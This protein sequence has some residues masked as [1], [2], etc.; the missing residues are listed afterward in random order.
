MIGSIVTYPKKQ[1][2][3]EECRVCPRRTLPLHRQRSVRVWNF[4]DLYRHRLMSHIAHELI[5][6]RR[7][8]YCKVRIACRVS[9]GWTSQA[10]PDERR[11]RL[12]VTSHQNEAVDQPRVTLRE[13]R[14][15]GSS[16]TG[17][18]LRAAPAEWF[19]RVL[20]GNTRGP[21]MSSRLR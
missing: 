21:R 3:W 13:G 15:C 1:N 16:S 18:L 2:V 11:D 19:L 17:R 20:G 8:A 6:V 4:P 7:H 10:C 14:T 12:M 5:A 9:R